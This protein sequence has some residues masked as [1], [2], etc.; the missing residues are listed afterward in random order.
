MALVPNGVYTIA[1][2]G[3]R[4]LT[5]RDGSAEPGTPTLLMPRS[6]GPGEQEWVL[7]ELD[8]GTRTIRNVRSGTLL[9]F[10]GAAEPGKQVGA[11]ARHRSWLLRPTPAPSRPSRSSRLFHLIVPDDPE[12]GLDAAELAV[13][14]APDPSWPCRVVLRPLGAGGPERA[15][16][17]RGVG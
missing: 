3:G 14:V 1:R 10:H 13:D 17:F 15:W 11:G 8:D 5:L 2:P 12:A 7:E 6:A 16:E 4:F 9:G